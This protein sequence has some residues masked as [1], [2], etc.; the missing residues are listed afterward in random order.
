[1]KGRD[2]L[3]NPAIQAYYLRTEEGARL[4]QGLGRLEYLRTQEI[5]Q[6][7]FPRPPARILDVGGGAGTY[8]FWLAKLGYEVHLVDIVQKHID[9][10]KESNKR[11]ESGHLAS[12]E[13][14]DALDL[15]HEDGFFDAVLMMGP[16]YHLTDR[17]DRVR[18]LREG[19]RVLGKRGRIACAYI[20]RYAS[21]IDGMLRN[22]T[23]NPRYLDMVKQ[24][25]D[26]G[27]WRNPTSEPGMFTTAYFHHA[28]EIEPELRDAGFTS[29]KTVAV[30]G[31]GWLAGDRDERWDDPNYKEKLLDLIRRT[32]HDD[33]SLAIGGHIMAVAVK[34]S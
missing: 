2:V 32:Q 27:Q 10:A 34:E 6:Q 29:T 30:E 23:D 8:S 33:L 5:V 11:I 9:Q 24:V 12:I 31:V 15:K 21:L 20:S 3:G 26:N 13:L 18:A 1:M 14:A 7:H 16:L 17:Q 28:E 25:L 19:W 22:L 4:F